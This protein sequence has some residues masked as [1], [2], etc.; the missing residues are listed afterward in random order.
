MNLDNVLVAL[1]SI[2]GIVGTYWLF[3]AK[4]SV[5]VYAANQID[6]LVDGGY[7]PDK[8]VVKRGR[9]LTLTIT[10]RDASSCL[11]EFLIPDFKIK[12]VLPLNTP[13]N[14]S[15]TPTEV[16]EYEFSCGMHMYFGKII[17]Q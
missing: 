13:I 8:I 9:E 10:R 2:L 17:V 14:I 3:F 6:I 16:G 4:K 5:P 1:L 12:R 7:T 11:E 15:I